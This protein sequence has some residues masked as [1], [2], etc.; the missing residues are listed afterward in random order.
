MSFLLFVAFACTSSEEP[1]D[2]DSRPAFESDTDTDTD[3]DGDIEI[4]G[5]WIDGFGSAQ[6]ITNDAWT[7]TYKGYPPLIVHLTEY[8]N[9]EHYAIGQNDETKS[10]DPLLW[11]RFDWAWDGTELYF[12]QTAYDAKSEAAAEATPAADSSDLGKTGSGCNGFPWSPLT[13]M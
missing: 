10:Y 1:T 8:D 13:A 5:D 3:T 11:S 12:C 4:A 7:T 6:T 2:S 9:A